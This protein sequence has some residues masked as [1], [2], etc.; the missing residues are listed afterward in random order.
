LKDSR[1]SEQYYASGQNHLLS[2]GSYVA[3]LEIVSYR[4]LL[5]F[6]VFKVRMPE[7][8]FLPI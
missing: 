1:G 2:G 5:Q 6:G 7:L 8:G 3:I 4:E